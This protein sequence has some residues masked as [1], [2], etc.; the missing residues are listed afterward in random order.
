MNVN[1]HDWTSEIQ[2][3]KIHAMG[4]DPLGQLRE[5]EAFWARQLEEQRKLVEE[6]MA[7]VENTQAIWKKIAEATALATGEVSRAAQEVQ[8]NVEEIA[9][10]LSA[11]GAKFKHTAEEYI[12]Q[13]LP[14][15]EHSG[16]TQPEILDKLAEQGTPYSPQSVNYAIGKLEKAGK[17]ARR[18][19]GKESRGRIAFVRMESGEVERRAS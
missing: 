18:P 14:S 7:Q 5:L 1:A 8:A 11:F 16:I 15:S 3:R 2:S 19:A 4:T 17:A 13:M 9:T 12:L 6:M 10:S